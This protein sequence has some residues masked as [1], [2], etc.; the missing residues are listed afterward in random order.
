M[1]G[2][3]GL[4]LIERLLAR[5]LVAVGGLRL[6]E[7]RL[8]SG[9]VSPVYV[10]MRSLLSDPRGRLA[11]VAGLSALLVQVEEELGPVDAVVGVATG[12]V[13]WASMLAAASGKPLG[14]VRPRAKE[15]GTGRRVEGAASGRV[16]VV[17]DVATTGGSVAS[18]AEALRGEG[19][20]PVAALVLVD[21]EQ[22]A[23]ERLRALGLR[24][25]RVATL[26]GLLSA[27]V[28]EGLL[29]RGEAEEALRRL[30]GGP[31]AL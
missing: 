7:F 28:G 11:A 10:D 20:E 17:D 13:P 21:R 25:Y 22:G 16:V 18:A 12:G 6:G 27:A 19:A 29:P 30:Y 15:H 2:L 26:R 4:A 1:Q 3:T 14:Y 8:T 23:A 9:A 5:R 31:Q 24:L